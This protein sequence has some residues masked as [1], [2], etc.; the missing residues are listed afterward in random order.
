MNAPARSSPLVMRTVGTSAFRRSQRSATT[1]PRAVTWSL[2]DP[3][4][5]LHSIDRSDPP[6]LVSLTQDQEWAEQMRQH[7][8]AA[9][10]M[11]A[12]SGANG[13]DVHLLAALPAA[14]ELSQAPTVVNE[15]QEKP[16][17]AEQVLLGELDMPEQDELADDEMP[18]AINDEA[19]SSQRERE[20]AQHFQRK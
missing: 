5:G 17:S 11:P 13:P 14:I 3:N 1:Q 9:P 20:S 15:A 12:E 2:P 8:Q 6:Q 19:N 10:Y 4:G 18:Q 16:T 7:P